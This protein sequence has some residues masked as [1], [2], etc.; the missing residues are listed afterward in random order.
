MTT[1]A[2]I[3]PLAA[4]FDKGS[5]EAW[6]ELV[7]KTLKGG[8]FEKR[9]VSRSADGIRIAPL[10]ERARDAKLI[11][12]ADADRPWRICQR[13]DHPDAK[14]A[15]ELALEDLQGGVDGLNLV[16]CGSHCARGFGLAAQ[17]VAE[18]DAALA[19]VAL[20]MITVRLEPAPGG[21]ANAALVAALYAHRGHDPAEC[22]IE[23]GMDP[24]GSMAA[25]GAMSA[26]WSSVAK[27]LGDAVRSL[28][29]QGFKGPFLT[30]DVRPYHEAGAS[31]AQELA[32]ALATGVAYLRALTDAGIGLED[33]ARALSW[34]IA[35]DADQFFGI[36]KLR[37]LRRLWARVE[38]A[39]GIAARP[40]RIHAESAWRMLTR[41]DPWVNMLR[42][43]MAAFT[44]GVAGADSITVLPHTAAL[45]LPDGFARRIARNT[46]IILQ[47]ESNIWRV[48]DPA[49][50]SGAYEGLTDDLATAAWALFQE[51]EAD[52]GMVES[53]AS[54]KIQ[55]RIKLIRDKRASDVA[56]RRVAL[57][58]TSEFPLLS[59][60]PVSVLDV[61]PHPAP[62]PTALREG[63]SEL[64]FSEL[65]ATFRERA[66]R[67]DVV[68]T[69]KDATTA[70]AL[71]SI[72]LSEPFEALRDASDKHLA[73]T[74]KRP[75]VFLAALGKIAEHKARSTWVCNLLAAGGIEALTSDGYASAEEAAAAF[76]ASGA[77]IACISSSDARYGELGEAT[78]KA[79]KA[80]GATRVYVAGRA[81]DQAAALVAAGVDGFIYAGQDVLA[82]LGELHAHL[83]IPTR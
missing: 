58:G 20:N 72:R 11:A 37:A 66:E 17:S 22:M 57:T 38:E 35:V 14:A 50:G 46:Q 39:S 76:K 40:I 74:G 32:T 19:G 15:S 82:L 52:G 6:V 5:H 42:G 36:A 41:R 80:E 30:C 73:S 29:S 47:E 43:T 3:R 79:L 63:D 27:R 12:R 65:I 77:S 67:S 83:G 31:E 33:A 1:E 81:I 53:L 54:G 13:V 26:P 71:P 44:A 69:A 60:A 4:D 61:A 51:I 62:P 24:I 56:S 21:R 10:Y 9:L 70:P 7:T 68:Q 16:F 64:T 23:F 45:G 75:Q 8:D 25:S 2:S 59:E 34:T 49:A 28:S 18:L 78:V 48:A 55:N